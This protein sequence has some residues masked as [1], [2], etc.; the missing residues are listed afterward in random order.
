MLEYLKGIPQGSILGPF[1]FLICI[2]DIIKATSYFS[3]R[4]FADDTSLTAT[5]KASLDVLLQQMKLHV[6]C[7]PSMNA[8]AQI[9]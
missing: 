2:N 7:Q 6:N 4:L 5:G 3:M 1:L 8:Y 9:N